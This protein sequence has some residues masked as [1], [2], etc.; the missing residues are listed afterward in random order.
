VPLVSK[1]VREVPREL[2]SLKVVEYEP[3]D[4]KASFQKLVFEILHINR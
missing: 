4:P 3:D 1:D 2:R